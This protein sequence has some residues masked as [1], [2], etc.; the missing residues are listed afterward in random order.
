MGWTI[1]RIESELLLVRANELTWTQEVTLAAVNRAEDLL[2]PN[3]IQSQTRGAK[4]LAVGVPIIQ[5]GAELRSLEGARN[6]QPLLDEI[7]RNTLSAFAELSAIHLLRSKHWNVELELYPEVGN[8]KPDFRIRKPGDP[9]TTTEVTNPVDSKALTSLRN[10]V[11]KLAKNLAQIDHPFSLEVLFT[12]APN[13]KELEILAARLPEFCTLNGRHHATLNDGLGHLFLNDVEVGQL[14]GHEV[15]EPGNVPLIGMAVLVGGPA[16]KP[17]RQIIVR[18]PFTDERAA[19]ILEDE[20][21]QLPRNEISLIIVEVGH[22]PGGLESWVPLL[23]RRFGPNINTRVSGVGLYKKSTGTVDGRYGVV[24][25]S[26]LVVNPHPQ[27][28]LPRWI[29]S[30]F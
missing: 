26:K 3:W 4:G 10:R 22:A 14:I 27:Q 13:E 2:G 30:G 1:E 8:R 24:L 12:K 28:K 17:T 20:A 7:R 29:Q 21:P 18:V 9:W 19:R 6:A 11:G 16:G 23:K 15:A 5:T 25:E